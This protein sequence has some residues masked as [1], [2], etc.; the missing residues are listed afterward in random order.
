M[1]NSDFIRLFSNFIGLD[2]KTSAVSRFTHLKTLNLINLK[3]TLCTFSD[4]YHM[5]VKSIK[6]L[7][8]LAINGPEFMGSK[9]RTKLSCFL[10]YLHR[11]MV[12]HVSHQLYGQEQ[13]Q[14]IN[15]FCT[16]FVWQGVQ[17]F[18][19]YSTFVLQVAS[20]RLKR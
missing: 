17:R 5:W 2:C 14:C 4:K 9:S 6:R 15:K 20:E 10:F 18:S 11:S 1:K 16:L 8:E 13:C 3:I 19:L 12:D 7:G